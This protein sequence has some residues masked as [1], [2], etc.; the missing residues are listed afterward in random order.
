MNWSGKQNSK[1]KEIITVK[2]KRK[3]AMFRLSEKPDSPSVILTDTFLLEQ[4]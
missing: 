4:I 2:E 1:A 3:I